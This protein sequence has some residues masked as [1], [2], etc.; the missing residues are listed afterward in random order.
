MQL[1]RMQAANAAANHPKENVD[2][3]RDEYSC[4]GDGRRRGGRLRGGGGP[5]GKRARGG[6][7]YNSAISRP[8]RGRTGGPA[9]THQFTK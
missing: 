6:G 4:R 9:A 8:S 7:V 1:H 5:S 2:D 3:V